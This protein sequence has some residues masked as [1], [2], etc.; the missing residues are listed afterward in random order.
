MANVSDHYGG[1]GLEARIARA[2]T[3]AGMGDQAIDWRLLAPLDQFHVRGLAAS[4]ELAEGLGLR[5]GASIL[6]VGS[7]L[8][9]P[10]RHLASV[11]GCQVTGVDLNPA[12]VDVARMLANR[13]GLTASVV[14]RQADALDLPFADASFDHAW[15]QHVAMNIQDKASLYRSIR[16][17]LKP[18]GRLAIYDVVQGGGEPLIFPVPWAS[19]PD[20][21]FLATP[22]SMR[23]D[24]AETGF[25]ERAWSDKTELGLAWFAEQQAARQSGSAPG[26]L[27]LQV[28][29]GPQMAIMAAN[30]ARNL[31]EGRARLVQVIVE[32]V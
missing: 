24:L 16:R 15:T 3:E 27:G 25:A 13:T 8:G 17:V 30:L 14:F 4:Q 26:P 2:M 19:A 29:M 12:F 7:G 1:D 9:G 11:F 31:A 5:P 6:D 22:E 10:A 23:R 32:R 20:I 28:V 18:G 21:S